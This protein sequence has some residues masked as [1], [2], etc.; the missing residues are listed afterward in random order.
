MFNIKNKVLDNGLELITVPMPALKSVTAMML[1]NTG[2]RFE[3]DAFQGSAHLLEH[4]IF[5][6]TKQYPNSLDLSIALDGIGAISN[7]FTSKE[8]TG[9]YVTAASSHL[10]FCL[11]ILKELI[12]HP[13]LR[14]KDIEQEKQVVAEEIRMIHDSPDDFISDK[15]EQMVFQGTGLE[16]FIAGSLSSVAALNSKKLTL[17]LQEWYGLENMVLVLAGDADCL[18]GEDFFNKI[19]KIFD[20]QPEGRENSHDQKRADF[21]TD[22]PI[23]KKK[24]MQYKRDTEQTH[25]V[26]GWPA[27]KRD[28]PQRYVLTVL[29]T[30]LGGNRSSR[31]FHVVRE[32]SS[33]AYYIYTDVSQY[34]DGGILETSAGLNKDRSDEGIELIINE[35]EK[36]AG[37]S[38]PVTAE[39]LQRA[40]EYLIGKILLSLENS[41]LV[42]QQHGLSR[43]LLNRI[44]QPDEMIKG[45]RKVSVKQVNQLAG[46]II[47]KNEVRVARIGS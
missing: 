2:S 44:E 8:S 47:Q 24:Q 28:D 40:Q 41:R 13:L 18:N 37:G 6:G 15:F 29:S 31:L 25:V 5:K 22:N 9:Y 27:L 30:V 32:Q 45:I 12:F 46:K 39:E 38:E 7:A 16:H 34:H 33:L 42:A 35:C 3:T 20:S 11:N 4:L 23:S 14:E 10:F 43:I 17:F 26:L 36:I 21:L 19:E 1:V